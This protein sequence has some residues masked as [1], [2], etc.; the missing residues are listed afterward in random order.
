MLLIEQLQAESILE[1]AVM[2]FEKESVESSSELKQMVSKLPPFPGTELKREITSLI[3]TSAQL[4]KDFA[5]KAK[6]WAADRGYRTQIFDMM[7]NDPEKVAKR[8][9][10]NYTTAYNADGMAFNIRDILKDID[11]DLK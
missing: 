1:E 11:L 6:P 9:V 2:I 3:K 7:L 10:R 5:K 8:L 4:I